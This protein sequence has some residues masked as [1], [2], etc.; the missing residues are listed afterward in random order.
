M[1]RSGVL[2]VVPCHR[3]TPVEDLFPPQ[4]QDEVNRSILGMQHFHVLL[5]DTTAEED[6]AL[7]THA[8]W[9]RFLHLEIQDEDEALN[10]FLVSIMRIP[11][12]SAD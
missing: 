7:T 9:F 6:W 2:I 1:V 11:Q 5:K 4:F 10:A 8:Q 12:K 3:P